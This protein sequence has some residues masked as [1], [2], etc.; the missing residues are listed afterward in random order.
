MNEKPAIEKKYKS[1]KFH[2]SVRLTGERI[3]DVTNSGGHSVK[4]DP[5]PVFGGTESNWSPEDLLLSGVNACHLASFY[6]YA[7]RK[8][9]EFSAYES[10]IEGLLEHEGTGFRFTKMII[11]PKITVK[12]EDDIETAKQYMKRAH[13]ICFMGHSVNA[14]VTVETEVVVG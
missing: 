3:W 9:F 14:E 8:G 13:Q 10:E 1:H 4:G 7:T 12:S 2:T 5:P 6:S 11:R